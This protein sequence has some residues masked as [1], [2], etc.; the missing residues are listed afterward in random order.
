MVY[1]VFFARRR[2]G[3]NNYRT[4]LNLIPFK[5]KYSV[6]QQLNVKTISPQKDFFIDLFGNVLMF[7]PFPLALVWLFSVK[8][9]YLKN[10]LFVVLAS[11]SIEIIQYL[12]NKGVSDI[13]DIFLNT[14]G[15]SIGL[16]VLH[17]L[18]QIKKA[19]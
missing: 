5:E 15:G 7:I 11:L 19:T 4:K 16:L 9:S 8:L 18:I 12:F 13:D 3:K 10:F 1:S 14:I 6:I 2:F 17:Y